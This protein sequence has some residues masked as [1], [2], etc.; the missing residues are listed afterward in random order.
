MSKAP[1]VHWILAPEAQISPRFVLQA[2][3]FEIQACR[4]LKCTEWPR[5]DH[6]HL[7]VKKA[8]CVQNSHTRGPNFTVFRSTVARFPDNRGFWFPH[9]VQWWILKI[10]KKRNVKFSKIQDST[11]VRTT[12]KKIQKKCERIQKW[13]EGGVAFWNFSS[14]VKRNEKKSLKFQF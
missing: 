4:N 2:G 1:C 6:K 7:N 8:P 14:H 13:F 3:T 12:E 11:F 10:F 9:R 5:N